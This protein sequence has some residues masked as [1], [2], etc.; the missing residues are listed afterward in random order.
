MSGREAYQQASRIVEAVKG[1]PELLNKMSGWERIFQFKPSDGEPFY[2]EVS[3]NTIRLVEGLHPTPTST[4]EA[5]QQ[6]LVS[7]MKGELDAVKAFFS[8]RLKVR[9]N[10]FATQELNDILSSSF[11]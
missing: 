5:S 2:I 6:D 1:R 3:S 4:I 10:I 7:V 8:G 9:G 11:K